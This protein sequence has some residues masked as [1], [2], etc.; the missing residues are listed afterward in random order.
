[1]VDTA[2]ATLGLAKE[3]TASP[4]PTPS[5]SGTQG[6]PGGG[7]N[8]AID[9]PTGGSADPVALPGPHVKP[10][11]V[12]RTGQAVGVPLTSFGAGFGDRRPEL[13][14]VAGP[15]QGAVRGI[16]SIPI[17]V[18]PLPSSARNALNDGDGAA[19]S[20]LPGLLVVCAA[21]CVAAVAAG[22][23]EVW[24]RRLAETLA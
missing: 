20:S 3:P 13:L 2:L 18:A 15:V 5:P 4:S 12:P 11:G 14:G 24:R 16:G 21:A 9:Q 22:N 7:G 23:A 6:S 1:V 8:D 19:E 10:A 17:A